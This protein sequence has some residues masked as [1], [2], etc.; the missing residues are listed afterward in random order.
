MRAEAGR[1]EEALRAQA[2]A[3]E[4]L[5]SIRRWQTMGTHH[6]DGIMTSG[7]AAPQF[8]QT[9]S[10]VRAMQG[11]LG[12]EED[13][14][15]GPKTE[16]A[17]RTRLA[18][19]EE[20]TLE[21]LRRGTQVAVLTRPQQSTKSLSPNAILGKTPAAKKAAGT[22]AESKQ[23]VPPEASKQKPLPEAARLLAQSLNTPEGIG[24]AYDRI[25]AEKEAAWRSFSTGRANPRSPQGRALARE[26]AKLYTEW[27]EVENEKERAI[28]GWYRKRNE[29]AYAESPDKL[30]EVALE[31]A[32]ASMQKQGYSTGSYPKNR[33]VHDMRQVFSSAEE[34]FTYMGSVLNY[35]TAESQ[36]E[37]MC[38]IYSIHL[39]DGTT[40]Y[41]AGPVYTG[42]H[43]NVILPYLLYTGA[44]M[45]LREIMEEYAG[46][47]IQYE[48]MLH[49]HPYCKGHEDD[50]FSE[51]DAVVALLSGKIWLTAPNGTVY[52]LEKGR[53]PKVLGA[54]LLRD[55]TY[56]KANEEQFAA[57]RKPEN[58]I[59]PGVRGYDV[60]ADYEEMD[61]GR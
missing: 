26:Q 53:A 29:A 30:S 19:E 1:G 50:K 31:D 54:S 46:T 2:E 48:G 33:K 10:N 16:L 9:A 59:V 15:W 32:K 6:V 57:V 18:A 27:K 51:G 35:C 24:R 20:E 37:H 28:A 38:N 4:Q 12:I 11:A 60:R 25:L 56:G 21:E 43:D 40:E 3:R 36:Q 17:F 58:F 23:L 47:E 61:D 39:E 14:V 44:E 7:I 55:T 34:I 5:S 8:I 41:A 13:G 49:S 45:G 42:M 22:G 52:A